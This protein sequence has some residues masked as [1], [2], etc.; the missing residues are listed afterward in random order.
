MYFILQTLS[1]RVAINIMEKDKQ[2][3]FM[4]HNVKS[5]YIYMYI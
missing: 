2:N 5:I 1:D 3:T 4:A